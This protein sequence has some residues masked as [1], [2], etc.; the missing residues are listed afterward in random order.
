[1]IA[2]QEVDG[3][4]AAKRVFSSDVY[5]YHFAAKSGF[6]QVGFIVKKEIPWQ[7]NPDYNA[8]DVNGKLRP[9]ADITLFPNGKPVRLLVLHL[10][11]G[12]F[13]EPLT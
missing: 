12:C 5:E 6:Q 8:L 4:A 1:M 11:S 13:D 9:G 3:V 2:V 10:K 7:A